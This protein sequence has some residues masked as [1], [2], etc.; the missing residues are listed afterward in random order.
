MPQFDKITFFNQV[1]WL[2]L[3]FSGFYLILLTDF[4]PKISSVLKARIK[5]LQKGTEDV[6]FFFKEEDTVTNLFNI[7]FGKT[8]FISKTSLSKFSEY[9]C[10]KLLTVILFMTYFFQ[11]RGSIEETLR[12]RSVIVLTTKNDF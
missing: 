3:F 8:S 1:F 9:F 10:L 5:K 12:F 11:C 7:F 2:F 6:V 4:L